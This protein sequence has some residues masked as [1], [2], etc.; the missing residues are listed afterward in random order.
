[1]APILKLGACALALTVAGAACTPGSESVGSQSVMDEVAEAYVRLVLA[2]GEHDADYVDA[3]YG[4]PQ[5]RDEVTAEKLG[6]PTITARAETLIHRLR[7][8]DPP[9]QELE[10]LRY[11]YLTTQLGSLAA[12]VD[13]LGG[14]TMTFDEESRALYDAVA[15]ANP[16][17]YYLSILEEL[18]DLLP[19]GGSIAERFRWFQS[20]FVIPPDRLDA[21]FT[22]AI[23]ECRERTLRQVDLPDGENFVL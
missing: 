18:D 22:R 14:R 11:T 6:L 19:P 12:R 4:P 17:E 23:E 8:L 13:M 3:Y 15:P 2:V 10:R 1:M 21:V 20:G 9:D 5:W 16:G 7:T